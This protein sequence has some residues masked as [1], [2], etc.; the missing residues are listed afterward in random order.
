MENNTINDPMKTVKCWNEWYWQSTRVKRGKDLNYP[1]KQTTK[2]SSGVCGQDAWRR[3][4]TQIWGVCCSCWTLKPLHFSFLGNTW[5]NRCCVSVRTESFL[6]NVKGGFPFSEQLQRPP[7]G[8]VQVTICI[9]KAFFFLLQIDC[10]CS[11]KTPLVH[12][13]MTTDKLIK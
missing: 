8:W 7:T 10:V 3:G 4:E 6:D 13:K 5:S 1:K 2:N 9:F 11:K 12:K